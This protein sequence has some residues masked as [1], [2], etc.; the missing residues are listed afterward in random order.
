MLKTLFLVAAMVMATSAAPQNVLPPGVD[1]SCLGWYPNCPQN[2]AYQQGE[3]NHQHYANVI[4]QAQIARAP[5][6]PIVGPAGTGVINPGQ[7]VGASGE[8]I[9]T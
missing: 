3:L 6:V 8:V 7:I 4:Q 5:F 1:P 2:L 9:Y